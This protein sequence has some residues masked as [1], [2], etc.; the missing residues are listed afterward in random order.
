MSLP[1]LDKMIAIA[2]A[3]DKGAFAGMNVVD[4]DTVARTVGLPAEAVSRLLSST[5]L[6][7]K[8]ITEGKSVKQRHD[9][10]Y[11]YPPRIRFPDAKKIRQPGARLV[12][13]AIADHRLPRSFTT[14]LLYHRLGSALTGGTI[15]P[16]GHL[17]KSLHEA[18]LRSGFTSHRPEG[19]KPKAIWRPATW[20]APWDR[21]DWPE[22]FKEQRRLRLHG[23]GLSAIYRHTDSAAR[24][25]G[26]IKDA[27]Q[28]LDLSGIPY[29]QKGELKKQIHRVIKQAYSALVTDQNKKMRAEREAVDID[30]DWEAVAT[31]TAEQLQTFAKVANRVARSRANPNPGAYALSWVQGNLLGAGIDGVAVNGT[32]EHV[33]AV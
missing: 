18:L 14:G 13:E 1:A 2:D 10:I 4:T 3:F 5:S 28:E 23:M 7:V 6:N 31:L 30:V 21:E 8:R 15:G 26:I 11:E 17:P 32:N 29:D 24:L 9:R 22:L 33:S 16:R 20:E 25:D 27:V 19:F 12:V